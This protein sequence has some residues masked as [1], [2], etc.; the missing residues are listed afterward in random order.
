MKKYRGVLEGFYETGTEGV[1]WILDKQRSRTRAWLD[2]AAAVPSTVTGFVRHAWKVKREG[3]TEPLSVTFFIFRQRLRTI[4]SSYG[5]MVMIDE[6]D[7]LTVINPDGTL[8][9]DGDIVC[10]RAAGYQPYPLNP[11]LGQPCA[12]GY[13]IHWTQKGWTPEAWATLFM[14]SHLDAEQGGGEPLRAIL[15]KK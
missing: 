7:H 9:F 6:G 13:W 4:L 14:C 5:D 3:G 1:V 12:L 15:I 8:A 11:S 2:L 10:D